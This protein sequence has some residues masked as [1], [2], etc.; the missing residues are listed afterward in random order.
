MDEVAVQVERRDNLFRSAGVEPFMFTT[1]SEAEDLAVDVLP[2]Y[3]SAGHD[4]ELVQDV[5]AL[6]VAL[7]AFCPHLGAKAVRFF[8]KLTLLPCLGVFPS[9]CRTGSPADPRS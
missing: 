5:V 7:E 8:M 1:T 6:A 3:F 4:R 9:P 2:L